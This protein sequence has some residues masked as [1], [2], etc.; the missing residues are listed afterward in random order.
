MREENFSLM[1][2]TS[3]EL[4]SKWLNFYRR[5]IIFQMESKDINGKFKWLK[6]W[7]TTAISIMIS[8]SDIYGKELMMIPH[9]PLEP[10]EGVLTRRYTDWRHKRD[11]RGISIERA[12]DL[13]RKFVHDLIEVRSKNDYGIYPVVNSYKIRFLL[14]SRND[15]F[16]R[17]KNWFCDSYALFST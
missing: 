2:L 7:S 16:D 14:P 15:R 13:S 17:R 6:I 8:K 10:D 12:P 5:N 9:N 3:V 11:F 4:K 1:K